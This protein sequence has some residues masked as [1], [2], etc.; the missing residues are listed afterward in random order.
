MRN[1][2]RRQEEMMRL[3][4]PRIPALRRYARLL[5]RDAA[6]ADDLVQD[7]LERTFTRWHQRRADS[8]VRPWMFSIL[9]NLAVNRMRHS[10]R[11]GVHVPLDDTHEA[12]HA[13]AACQEDVLVYK[14]LLEA[15]D[16][17]PDDQRSVLLL[18]AMEELSYAEAAAI[19]G[20]PVGTVMSRL[21]RARERLQREMDVG[22]PL[23]TKN[24]RIVR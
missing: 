17:L 2:D 4:E 5:T 12:T 1:A 24:L 3:V 6:G 7:C 14:E 11:R 20:I 18:V 15:V 16:R 22:R 23:I 10:S 19:L 8:D 9:H 13:Q 21:S